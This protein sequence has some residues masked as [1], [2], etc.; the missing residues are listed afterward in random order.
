MRL[1][2]ARR[3]GLARHLYELGSSCLRG[4]NDVH[5]FAAVNLFQDAVEAFLLAV[6]EHVGASIDSRTDFD[7]YF[8]RIN[9]KISPKELPFKAA[10]VRLN[11][12]RINSKHYGIQPSRTECENLATSVRELFE[13]VSITIL[14]ANF[15]TVSALDLIE[16]GEAKGALESAR[17]ALNEER[18]ADCLVECRKAI[19]LEIEQKYNIR[20]FAGDVN[21][22]GLLSAFSYAP[23]FARNKNYIETSVTNPTEF[24]VLDHTRVEQELLSNGVDIAQFWNIWRLTPRVYRKQ[25]GEWIYQNDFALLDINAASQVAEYI[26]SATTDILLAISSCRKKM[27][28]SRGNKYFA[29][30]R[31]KEVNVYAKADRKSKVVG[32]LP[33]DVREVD[34]DYYVQGLNGDG[35]Y[36][37]IR[38]GD[39]LINSIYGYVFEDDIDSSCE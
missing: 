1:E 31:H 26:F 29:R 8:V 38:H 10:M 7:K 32:Q 39:P 30:L 4:T 6:A 14:G 15:A 24:I 3:I 11:R 19:Y 5:L 35:I 21:F 23:Y 28:W 25:S 16:A 13:E 33:P 17:T 37:K 18:F 22:L 2:I 27:K 20:Q 34:T 12:L 9:E 36:W